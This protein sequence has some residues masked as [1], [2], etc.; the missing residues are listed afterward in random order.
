M[1]G[2]ILKCNGCGASL[3]HS[4]SCQVAPLAF[5]DERLQRENEELREAIRQALRP[6]DLDGPVRGSVDPAP[7]RRVLER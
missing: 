2:I 3:T 6:L 7:L 5:V 1:S 4:E